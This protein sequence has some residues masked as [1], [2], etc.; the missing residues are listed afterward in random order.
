[1]S[2]RGFDLIDAAKT[3]VEEACP[4]VVSCADII[5]LAVQDSVALVRTGAE[6]REL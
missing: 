1:M 2:I 4:S 6:Y 5:N 3:A